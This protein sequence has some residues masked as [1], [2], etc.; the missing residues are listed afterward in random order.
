MFRLNKDRRPQGIS[1][2][3][4]Y[5]RGPQSH[6]T[7]A[8]SVPRQGRSKSWV[9]PQSANRSPV[10]AQPAQGT[11]PGVDLSSSSLQPILSVSG[12]DTKI[13]I[14]PSLP[15]KGLYIRRKKNT[16]TRVAPTATSNSS[17]EGKPVSRTTSQ[18]GRDS[19]RLIHQGRHKLVQY[20]S[21][22]HTQQHNHL[23]S[24]QAAQTPTAL[25]QYR[26]FVSAQ[27]R[28]RAGPALTAPAAKKVHKWVRD[29]AAP[30]LLS[31]PE[32]KRTML[33]S[34]VSYVRSSKNHKL[35]LVRRRSASSA[36]PA[37]PVPRLQTRGVVLAKQLLS[38]QS[39]NRTVRS[40]V[41]VN[42]SG[43]LKPGK[44]RR[45]G[46]VLYKVGGSKHGKSLQRQVTPKSIKPLLSPE[47]SS[48]QF[49]QSFVT[50]CCLVITRILHSINIVIAAAHVWYN[51]GGLCKA[52]QAPDLEIHPEV[53]QNCY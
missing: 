11:V 7:T 52:G 39:L 24:S 4:V 47:V 6:K 50:T 15:Q 25:Q 43:V 34:S 9:R 32:S 45:I 13:T 17:T 42:G 16:L 38:V 23:H 53:T 29:A 1:Q 18:V 21:G 30:S 22:Q 51:S 41:K 44:L 48:S 37:T 49:A 19:R 5:S 10:K 46:G 35:Q 28:K 36:S 26:R 8:V 3:P 33:P 31:D 2:A 12:A 14:P 20:K 27:N 40:S